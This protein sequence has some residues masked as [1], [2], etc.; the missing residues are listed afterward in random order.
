MAIS[1]KARLGLVIA[2]VLIALP[3]VFAATFGVFTATPPYVSNGTTLNFKYAAQTLGLNVTVNT[4]KINAGTPTLNL[5][6]PNNDAVYE[7]SILVT[8]TENENLTITTNVSA[9][10]N[11]STAETNV[12]LDNT[13]PNA[14]IAI[15]DENNDGMTTTKEVTLLLNYSD[16]MTNQR[17]LGW[18][19]P[20]NSPT[21]ETSQ[22]TRSAFSM[23]YDSSRQR[24]VIFGGKV[25]P[26][27]QDI[28]LND[29]WEY[30]E[31]APYPY[32]HA[33]YAPLVYGGRDY[34]SV[35]YVISNYLLGSPEI[36]ADNS[37]VDL[38]GTENISV[39]LINSSGAYATVY[40][41][42]SF[43]SNCTAVENFFALSGLSA[44]C[45]YFDA[46]A[47]QANGA[48][49]DYT[50]QNPLSLVSG[51]T[52][53]PYLEY[54]GT[55][56]KT[57]WEKI[58]TANAP[59]PRANYAMAYDSSRNK[60]VLFGGSYYNSSGYNT[61]YYND[62][63]E[64]D[65]T[66]WQKITTANA[67]EPRKVVAMTFD[68]SRN[69]IVLFGGYN[70]SANF[71]DTWEYDG[72]N[73]QKI[74]TTN[75]PNECWGSDLPHMVYYPSRDRIFFDGENGWEY[76]PNNTT[77]TQLSFGG[78]SG[79]CGARLAYDSSLDQ[80]IIH[81][82]GA[83]AVYNGTTG[84]LV[85]AVFYPIQAPVVYDPVREVGIIYFGIIT[86]EFSLKETAIPMTT[87]YSWQKI[88]T[89]GSRPSP[90]I[91]TMYFDRNRNKVVLLGGMNTGV[92]G[93]YCIDGS[94]EYDPAT[95]AWQ[96]INVSGI[97]NTTIMCHHAWNSR[98][99]TYDSKRDRVVAFYYDRSGSGVNMSRTIECDIPAR[100]CT[101]I[102]SANQ[103]PPGSSDPYLMIFDSDKNV[104]KLFGPTNTQV[105]EYDG[106][107]WRYVASTTNP[108]F[109]GTILAGADYIP[110]INGILFFGGIGWIYFP[111]LT[112]KYTDH[113][114]LVN[115][116]NNPLPRVRPSLLYDSIRHRAV[117]FGGGDYGPMTYFDTW[118]FY[119]TTWEP[120]STV[121]SPP[122][123]PGPYG[124]VFDPVRNKIIL[125]GGTNASSSIIY[126]DTWEASIT[127]GNF[128]TYTSPTGGTMQMSNIG[129]IKIEIPVKDCRYRNEVGEWTEWVPCMPTMAW[130][131]SGGYGYKTVYYQV[132]DQAGNIAEDSDTIYY[133]VNGTAPQINATLAVYDEG[134]W[135]NHNSS[136]YA[137]WI[138]NL[139][140]NF[141]YS[142]RIK[143]VTASSYIRGWTGVSSAMFVNATG[144][145]LTNNHNYTFEVKMYNGSGDYSWENI[146]T[147]G[148]PDKRT[149]QGMVYD[150]N[151]NRI[152]VFGGYT[153]GAGFKND[154]WEYNPAT[155][156]W[157]EITTTSAPE[158]GSSYGMAYDSSRGKVVLYGGQDISQE[159][160]N[161]T[162]EYSPAAR[163]WTKI[164]TSTNPPRLNGP[165]M[166]YDSSR[167]KIV[168]F[169]GCMN[170]SL[171][172]FVLSCSDQTWEYDGIN[173]VNVSTA[174]SP[175]N[176]YCDN[177]MEFDSSRNKVVLFG[178]INKTGGS[179]NFFSDTWEFNGT[180]WKK[181]NL[182]SPAARYSQSTAF[183]SSTGNVV[184]FGGLISSGNT[185]N[186][187]WLFDGTSWTQL[188]PANGPLGR[189]QQG[190]VFDSSRNKIVMFGGY[191]NP[192][193]TRFNDTWELSTDIT[194]IASD[195]SDGIKIDTIPPT[196]T[197]TSSTHPNQ[198]LTY[199]STAVSFSWT[200]SDTPSGIYGF[201][202]LID[203]NP[204]T[205]PDNA[206]ELPASSTGMTITA[207]SGTSWFHFKTLDNAG[208]YV[209]RHYKLTIVAAGA[210]NVMLYPHESPTKK[211]LIDLKG[212]ISQN[213]TNMT[214]F[215]NG[216]ASNVSVELKLV[217]LE[218]EFN[219]VSI[220]AGINS[221]Y[222]V[223]Y[224]NGSAVGTS[225]TIYVKRISKTRVDVTEL[226][227][228]CSGCSVSNSRIVYG[229][230]SDAIPGTSRYP[231]YGAGTNTGGTPVAGGKVTG[232][233]DSD[234][235]IFVTKP[236]APLSERNKLLEDRT[237]FDKISP[238]MGFD[239]N[240]DEYQ[241]NILLN[242]AD[243]LISGKDYV[244]EGKY[245]L[246]IKNNGLANG[247]PNVSIEII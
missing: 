52:S 64:Y 9:G 227:I 13:P 213:V 181:I 57:S 186:D 40:L 77:W 72:T 132:R 28:Y 225:N 109:G 220:P 63:W 162:W 182:A 169:G 99:W 135:S 131:L 161:E 134:D 43:A 96:E 10:A 111:S 87:R 21:P 153:T 51:A 208:N 189:Y 183:D 230:S 101:E 115:T 223:A 24:S 171:S 36:T 200:A 116:V 236:E 204:T 3:A 23:V 173:W 216:I 58:N 93:S 243:L 122:V 70:G 127:T 193:S 228:E 176:R 205:M 242:Y 167:G 97:G 92:A 146:S 174:T 4:F 152:I 7:G 19:T 206:I 15:F 82:G 231:K 121:G 20:V 142:Y 104:V 86:W 194:E 120:A 29:T 221:I 207:P 30:L 37:T 151:R 159:S 6:D 95:H 180:D 48:G 239:L 201:S 141:T 165:A 78:S 67:P 94:W 190:M 73:W 89:T 27:Y 202:Y 212:T 47:W 31:P 66:N 211:D 61:L 240:P 81:M 195:L 138:T 8:S 113:W 209:V 130:V 5:T 246:V 217:D 133:S 84:G 22:S 46:N 198:N 79:S 166:T 244:Q 105:W 12:I 103:I 144:L 235:F 175:P 45:V 139:A 107:Q 241:L 14:S 233:V 224:I 75:A 2:L 188:N 112:Y 56:S 219:N 16:Y 91:S 156:T 18:V 177:G 168:M 100:T 238:S 118:E 215:V 197:L 110:S 53:P 11:L 154:T 232:A 199:Y 42:S 83:L 164:S 88:T 35:G 163:T 140:G 90:R 185:V 245:T 172:P 155:S 160:L 26:S 39:A 196:I 34:I 125:F 150:S 106:A 55:K 170:V 25:S 178:G 234:T 192:T 247:V 114:A 218:F 226:T 124:S 60:V 102:S 148:A 145:A 62:T 117:M 38:S 123:N 157:T 184:I 98:D 71:N 74:T 119:D 76:N 69:R 237:L 229:T 49:S 214:L 59:S 179:A 191:N 143:D 80:I 210:V 126:N 17:G 129:G 147:I 50:W 108:P 85:N 136:L 33:S 32:Y 41:Y 149:N 222:A 54:A 128:G 203:S 187:T 68:S 1:K 158:E 44:D 65:G 137:H